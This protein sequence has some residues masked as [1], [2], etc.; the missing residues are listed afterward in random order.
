[1]NRSERRRVVVRRRYSFFASINKMQLKSCS[2]WKACSASKEVDPLRFPEW[3]SLYPGNY[4]TPLHCWDAENMDP[5]VAIPRLNSSIVL[6]KRSPELPP[7]DERIIQSTE[8]NV[9]WI[10]EL[11]YSGFRFS[12]LSQGWFIDV[13]DYKWCSFVEV[14]V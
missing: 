4:T 14:S 12:V 9:E 6:V 5:Y 8:L 3:F 1:M 10:M 13:K 11:R 7:F 2:R